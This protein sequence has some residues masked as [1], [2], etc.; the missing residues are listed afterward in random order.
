MAREAI[1]H[2][3]N[4][5]ELHG[6]RYY[7]MFIAYAEAPESIRE[8]RLPHDVVYAT[9]QDGDRILVEAILSMVTGVQKQ[10]DSSSA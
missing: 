9:P 5:Y 8:V 7:Q 3:V 6:V 10:P 4:P 2:K 1:L